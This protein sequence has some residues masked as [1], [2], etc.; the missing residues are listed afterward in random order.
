MCNSNDFEIRDDYGLNAYYVGQGGIVRIPDEIDNDD[1]SLQMRDAKNITELHFNGNIKEVSA[2]TF[3]VGKFGSDKTIEKIVFEEGT[4]KIWGEACFG[5]CDNLSEVL[6]PES[7]KYLGHNAFKNSPWLKNS[8]EEIEG[9]IYLG[10]F[11]I[12]SKKDIVNANVRE[13]TK[14]ICGW[15]FK[16]RKLLEN[17]QV[18]DSVKI[19]GEQAFAGCSSL[20]EIKLSENVELIED[21]AFSNCESLQKFEVDN[22]E[23]SI[24]V[25]SFGSDKSKQLFLPEYAH[26]PNISFDECKPI[27]KIFFL[28][29]YLTCRDKYSE[30]ACK[31]CDAMVK[32]SKAKLLDFI[33]DQG[34][35]NAF[36]NICPMVVTK[37]NV[38]V[39]LQK[40][41]S[42]NCTEMTA[43]LLEFSKK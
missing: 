38:D 6:L 23:I 27:Q 13:G 41:Q 25:N 36:R 2:W 7:L 14:M 9:C 28:A 1:V 34:N 33:I 24:A 17:I 18:P 3:G 10:D 40:V 20:K 8:T 15:A 5:E 26:I 19:I 37:A 12:D 30:E 29:C 31:L 22:K 21:S 16:G 32:K 42:F 43:L 39:L 11:L 35:V 4:E